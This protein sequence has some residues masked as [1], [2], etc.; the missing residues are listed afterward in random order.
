[1]LRDDTYNIIKGNTD[2]EHAF[3]LFLNHL[4]ED[5]STVG[6]ALLK[7]AM[8]QTI[9][10]LN[11][12]TREVGAEESSHYNFAVTDGHTVVATR[13]TDMPSSR[14][15]RFTSLKEIDLSVWG[16]CVV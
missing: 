13:Y 10:Q 7:Q 5:L 3:A 8:L 9:A 15:K 14:Q 1:M 4:P 6:P 16:M 12:W 11:E 2:T